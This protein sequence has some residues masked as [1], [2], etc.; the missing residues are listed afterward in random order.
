MALASA[1][2]PPFA[3]VRFGAVVCV[4]YNRRASEKPASS[5]ETSQSR[6]GSQLDTQPLSKLKPRQLCVCVYV[7][8]AAWKRC[9][10]VQVPFGRKPQ[11]STSPF[12]VVYSLNLTRRKIHISRNIWQGEQ[13]QTRHFNRWVERALD[14]VALNLFWKKILFDTSNIVFVSSS[15]MVPV[16]HKEDFEGRWV[17]TVLT[18]VH[19]ALSLSPL[20]YQRF[21]RIDQVCMSR[22]EAMS[23]RSYV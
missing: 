21:L 22:W 8:C 7:W 6:R 12:P 16:S 11:H 1:V 20:C 15:F 19:L 23:R 13:D 5:T 17:I 2:K 4:R 10:G 14:H 9:F 3:S 18:A